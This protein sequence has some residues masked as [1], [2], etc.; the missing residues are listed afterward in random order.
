M[1]T[2]LLLI[3][4]NRPQTTA[5]LIKALAEVRPTRLFITADGPRPERIKFLGHYTPAI[6]RHKLMRPR[7]RWVSG[8]NKAGFRNP[9]DA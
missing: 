5:R 2:P 6:H 7:E 4:F 1:D 3:V 9:G 8:R